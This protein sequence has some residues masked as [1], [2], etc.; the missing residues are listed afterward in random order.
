MRSDEVTSDFIKSGLE[1]LEARRL[2]NISGLSV[3]VFH[4]LHSE[5]VIFYPVW[6]YLVSTYAYR[7]LSC[8]GTP[9]W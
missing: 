9:L 6:T 3:P 8:H 5:R 4:G 2:Q 7:F 1:N